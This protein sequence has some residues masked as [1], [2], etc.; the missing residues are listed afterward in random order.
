VDIT[1]ELAFHKSHGKLATVLAVQPPGRYG[2][3]QLKGTTVEGFT[4]KPRGDG[5]LINGGFFVL[6]PKCIDLI[7]DDQTSWEGHPLTKLATDGQLP[8]F[9]HTGFKGGWL[10]LW[11]TELGAEVHGYL[12]TP[13]TNPNFFDACNLR[14]RLVSSTI[15]DIRDAES[16]TR[17]MQSTSPQIVLHLAA[18][19]LVRHSYAQPVETY[20]VN[21]MGTVN[22]LEPVRNTPSVPCVAAR[23]R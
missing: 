10:S 19:P 2:A 9:E 4:E 7:K 21:V 14:T 11:L 8:S 5:G 20:A 16:L 18:Q 13:A 12:L 1:K 17:A 3:L 15:A 23:P 6:S 22:V